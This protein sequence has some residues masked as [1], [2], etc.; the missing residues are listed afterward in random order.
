MIVAIQWLCILGA[1]GVALFAIVP[2]A[3]D[4]WRAMQPPPDKDSTPKGTKP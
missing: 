2:F 3:L 4:W 1:V